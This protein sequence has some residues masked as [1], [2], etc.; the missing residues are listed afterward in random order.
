[1]RAILVDQPG[2]LEQMRISKIPR[3][4]P[5]P[6]ELVVQVKATSLNRADILQRE[7]HYPPPAGESEIMGLD[8]AGVVVFKGR[9][10]DNLS[11]QDVFIE[12]LLRSLK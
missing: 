5:K 9:W 4:E 11:G 7:G 2:G 10:M 3:Q 12:R 8:V 6:H 1:M